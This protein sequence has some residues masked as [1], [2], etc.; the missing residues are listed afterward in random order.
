MVIVMV[1]TGMGMG[2]LKNN[3]LL[4]L[5]TAMDIDQVIKF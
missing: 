3:K 1:M 2:I 5:N 4:K